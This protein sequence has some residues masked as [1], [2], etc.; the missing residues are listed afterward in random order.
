MMKDKKLSPWLVIGAIGIVFGDI[1][2]SPLYALQSIFHLSN[3]SFTPNEIIGVISLILWSITLIVTIKYMSLLM[4][5]NNHGEGGIMA[6]VGLIRQTK[7][8]KKSI[9]AF[10]IFGMLGVSLFFG[11]GVITPAISVLSAVEGLSLLSPQASPFIVPLALLILLGLFYLQ[12]RGTG[13]LGKYF[14]PI[15]ILWFIVGAIGGLAQIIQYPSV[16]AALLPTTAIEFFISNPFPAFL[17]MGAVILSLTGAEALYA[18]MGHFGKTPIRIGWLVLI[19]PALALTYMGQ[20]ALVSLNPDSISSAYY[21]MFPS[22]LHVPVIILAT[23]ATLIA[24]QAVIAGAFSLIWQATR[25]NFLPR[26]NVLHTSRN[27]YGQVY[28]PTLNWV[29]FIIVAAIILAFQNSQNLSAMFGLAVSGTLLVDTIFLTIIM[30]KL[31]NS[32]Y[33]KIALVVIFIASL[34]L[35]FLTS[36][37]SKLMYGAWVALLMALATFTVMTTW[38]RGH[39]LIRAERKNQ[40]ITL[41]DFVTRLHKSKINRVDGNAVYIGHH[42]KN[43]PL[44]LKSTV[45]ELHELH[46]KVVIVTVKTTDSAHVPEEKRAKFSNLGYDGDG[47]S[48]ITLTFG[49]KDIPNVPH[50]L[51]LT[52]SFSTE[53]NFDPHKATYFTS[54]IQPVVGKN[55]HMAKW[56]KRLYLFMS[57]NASYQ[58]DYY[59]L[60][61]DHTIEM[62][63][64]MEL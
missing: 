13:T 1:G 44:A 45:E 38:N 25:L 32:S 17:A 2:T 58:S 9:A 42:T 60:P 29:M 33:F 63:T 62:K 47:I 11:D 46:H 6:L 15:M 8:S 48:H 28:I 4:R 39:S 61:A 20:G 18:D 56:R 51:E 54:G 5:V 16:L 50:A 7:S 40:E 27:E 53:V 31:W 14:G 23:I 19:F 57:R 55:R 64:F 37:L 12:S 10:T 30:R 34:E 52:R 22:Y 43:A 35:M 3:L 41:E 59:H 49:F 24:S 36:G 26:L 21:L